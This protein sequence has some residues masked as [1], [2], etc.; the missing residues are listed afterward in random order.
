MR[1]LFNRGS[2]WAYPV[3]AA[4]GGSF[5]Y[6]LTGVSDRQ[7]ALLEEQKHKL[8]EKRRR[9]DERLKAAEEKR[10]LEGGAEG[11][12]EDERGFLLGKA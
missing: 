6:W 9:R 7:T 1:P 10:L 11:V 3:F 5:G 8:L 4:V 12:K 2:L